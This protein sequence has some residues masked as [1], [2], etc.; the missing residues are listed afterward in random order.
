M[1]DKKLIYTLIKSSI[2]CFIVATGFVICLP[3]GILC[4]LTG[5]IITF[6]SIENYN[7]EKKLNK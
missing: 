4:I 3:G 2:G 1:I 6:V 5:S 7:E